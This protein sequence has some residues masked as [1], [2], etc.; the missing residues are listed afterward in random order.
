[1]A[2]FWQNLEQD[3]GDLVG[4]GTTRRTQAFNAA[5]AQKQRDW[6]ETMSN[7]SYQRAVADMK[8]AGLNPAMMYASGGQGASTPSGASASGSAS[9]KAMD[10]VG[11]VGSI[12]NSV[13]TARAIDMK[14]KQ[15]EM[16]KKT[17]IET[18][19]KAGDLISLII[20]TMT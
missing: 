19:N 3:F 7:T 2:N 17:A 4:W 5:E 1:M 14:Y 8:A 6:E 9:G 20:K 13:N 18:Y 10:I 16:P 15:N 11:A 12:M